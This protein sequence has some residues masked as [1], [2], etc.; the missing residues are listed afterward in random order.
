MYNDI[1]CSE[2]WICKTSLLPTTEPTQGDCQLQFA[3]NFK[4]HANV[5][6]KEVSIP[7]SDQVRSGRLYAPEGGPFRAQESTEHH[8]NNISA[9]LSTSFV[10]EHESIYSS[11]RLAHGVG[12]CERPVSCPTWV[13]RVFL[14]Q[15]GR[16]LP[17][18]VPCTCLTEVHLD[19]GMLAEGV[20]EDPALARG[21]CRVPRAENVV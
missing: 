7:T 1:M 15:H 19:V 14:R 2:P 18:T 6:N 8:L 5:T 20:L 21:S 10:P 16:L 12:F 4:K 13:S 9:L 3:T 17:R 11:Q